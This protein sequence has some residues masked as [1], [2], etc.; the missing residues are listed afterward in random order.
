MSG[1]TLMVCMLWPPKSQGVEGLH[2]HTVQHTGHTTY[3]MQCIT[4]YCTLE[5]TCWRQK[6]G[7]E[8]L[9]AALVPSC[10]PRFPGPWSAHRISSAPG[11]ANLTTPTPDCPKLSKLSDKGPE[12]L[13]LHTGYIVPQTDMNQSPVDC[14]H[15]IVQRHYSTRTNNQIPLHHLAK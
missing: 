13:G 7:A 2:E 12:R 15:T 3:C 9:L 5:S 14:Q 6:E 4:W 8:H 1:M 11:T 10:N